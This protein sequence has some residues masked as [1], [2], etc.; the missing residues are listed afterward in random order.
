MILPLTGRVLMGLQG[1]GDLLC[2]CG[3]EPDLCQPDEENGA[4]LVGTCPDCEAVTIYR[5]IL[6]PWRA[7]LAYELPT[8]ELQEPEP[9]RPVRRRAS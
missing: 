1:V 4:Q 2:S 8:F 7:A 3:A 6:E 9:L 5:D